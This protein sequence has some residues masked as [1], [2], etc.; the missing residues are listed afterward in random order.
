MWY[1][2]D[3]GLTYS[4]AMTLPISLILDLCAVRAIEQAGAERK[5]TGADASKGFA[6]MAQMR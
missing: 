1:A 4:Q 3:A 2:L 5:F 6:L